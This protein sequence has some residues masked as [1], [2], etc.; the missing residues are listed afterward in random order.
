MLEGWQNVF[1]DGGSSRV[2]KHTTGRKWPCGGCLAFV[3][4]CG[5]PRHFTA[6]FMPCGVHHGPWRGS[7]WVPCCWTWL[8][9]L[10]ALH[11]VPSTHCLL[12]QAHHELWIAPWCA[13]LFPSLLFFI[14]CGPCTF[15]ILLTCLWM[16]NSSPISCESN[17]A[18][19]KWLQMNA[20][21]NFR[22]FI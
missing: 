7:W 4:L 11:E 18:Q 21:S 3:A 10:V 5:L 22:N 16:Y 2:V 14:M 12:Y 9:W 17:Q 15:H 20:T 19:F 8:L 13:T 6:T 1:L